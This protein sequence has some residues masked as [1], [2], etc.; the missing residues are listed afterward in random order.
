MSPGVDSPEVKLAPEVISRTVG[1][2]KVSNVV[3]EVFNNKHKWWER[4]SNRD[5]D[6][7]M[8][9]LFDLSLSH[10]IIDTQAYGCKNDRVIYLSLMS[11]KGHSSNIDKDMM[12]VISRIEFVKEA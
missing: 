1:G 5:L 8:S 3:V 2:F 10:D 4:T 11:S 6:S 12:E 7:L 9:M